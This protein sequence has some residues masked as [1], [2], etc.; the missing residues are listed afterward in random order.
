MGSHKKKKTLSTRKLIILLVIIAVVI[1]ILYRTR[2]R[3]LNYT[4]NIPVPFSSN[5]PSAKK[6]DDAM[7]MFV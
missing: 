4:V 1:I 5:K 6:E 7:K 3:W 2:D